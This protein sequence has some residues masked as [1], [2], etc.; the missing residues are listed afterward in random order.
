MST[1]LT[2]LPNC[3]YNALVYEFPL[4][5]KALEIAGHLRVCVQNTGR[6][7]TTNLLNRNL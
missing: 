5:A 4:H 2:C 3:A 7:L 6:L 1:T